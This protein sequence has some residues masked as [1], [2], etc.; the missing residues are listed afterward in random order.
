MYYVLVFGVDFLHYFQFGHSSIQ[1]AASCRDSAMILVLASHGANPDYKYVNSP[2]LLQ[3][4][5]DMKDAATV[6]E[7]QV[8]KR[9]GICV[10][11]CLCMSIYVCVY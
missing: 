8:S 4:E 7:L 1:L 10:C 3:P 11:V 6:M 9:N 2:F 5:L